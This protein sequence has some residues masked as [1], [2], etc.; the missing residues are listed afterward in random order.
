MEWSLE[1]ETGLAEIDVQHRYF[2]EL[3]RC[4]NEVRVSA[5]NE[6]RRSLLNEL[7]GYAN[8]HFGYETALTRT[9]E[10]PGRVQHITE[11]EQILSQV[12][13][14]L[15]EDNANFHKVTMLLFNWLAAHST[16]E[17]RALAKHVVEYRARV[18][19]VP[20][21]SLGLVSGD[22]NLPSVASPQKS[23]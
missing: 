16:L 22:R 6:G 8:C 3:I 5:D 2:V 4:A 11:H 20:P 15:S 12:K 23:R 14:F 17:D 18:L 1:F 13:S 7:L 21:D 9:Y 19:S 10:Y